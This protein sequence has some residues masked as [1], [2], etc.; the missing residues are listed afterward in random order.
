MS[1]RKYTHMQ[2]HSSTILSMRNN[3]YTMYPLLEI[4]GEAMMRILYPVLFYTLILKNYDN[5][6]AANKRAQRGSK[7]WK[8]VSDMLSVPTAGNRFTF[9]LQTAAAL[10]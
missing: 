5:Q 10:S 1:K 6:E 7:T 2:G 8:K 4:N 3:G 9:H